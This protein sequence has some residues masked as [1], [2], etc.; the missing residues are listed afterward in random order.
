MPTTGPLPQA[1]VTPD[2]A[3]AD[4]EDPDLVVDSNGDATVVFPD[5]DQ[6]PVNTHD[7]ASRRR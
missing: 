7:A 3:N 6:D 2:E 5:Y 1:D 4:E